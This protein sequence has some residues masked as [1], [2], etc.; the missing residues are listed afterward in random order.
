MVKKWKKE[1][2]GAPS[3]H[4]HTHTRAHTHRTKELSRGVDKA[5]SYDASTVVQMELA[6]VEEFGTHTH[7][8]APTSLKR[9]T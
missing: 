3:T 4:R 7:I 8:E 5:Y 2:S 6:Q 9:F 1:R